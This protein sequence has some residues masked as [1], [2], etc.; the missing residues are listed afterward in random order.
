MSST[1]HIIW[2]YFFTNLTSLLQAYSRLP[3]D[4]CIPVKVIVPA[5]RYI[6]IYAFS[7]WRKEGKSQE[8]SEV[9]PFKQ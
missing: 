3:W 9:S 6:F 5:T 1:I 8:Y 2:P 7:I 4:K